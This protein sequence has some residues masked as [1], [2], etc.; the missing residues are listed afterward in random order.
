MSTREEFNFLLLL[1][2]ET[3]ETKTKGALL[4]CTQLLEKEVNA[5]ITINTNSTTA[6]AT[7]TSNAITT[8]KT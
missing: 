4:E 8:N 3:K 6:T 5:L 2:S 7:N 1:K